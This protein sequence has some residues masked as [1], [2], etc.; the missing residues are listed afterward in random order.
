LYIQL[1]RL[2]KYT[3]DISIGETTKGV[4]AGSTIDDIYIGEIVEGV[5]SRS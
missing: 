2:Q 4:E 3:N 5:E 1:N